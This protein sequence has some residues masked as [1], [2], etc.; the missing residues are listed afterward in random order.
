VEP[1]TVLTRS[2]AKLG[3]G[4]FEDPMGALED[5]VESHLRSF[6]S[7]GVHLP[8]TCGFDACIASATGANFS[9]RA[10]GR[11]PALA[12]QPWCERDVTLAIAAVAEGH[13]RGLWGAVPVTVCGGGHSEL[14]V[15]D[16]AVLLHFAKMASVRP[17]RLHAL[18]TS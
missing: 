11:R 17:G 2:R 18:A 7:G 14:C 12:L 16:G 9:T 1:E 4:A 13:R 8:G 3:D 10:D 6:T 15:V 5:L